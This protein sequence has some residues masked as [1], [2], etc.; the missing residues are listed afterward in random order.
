MGEAKVKRQKQAQQNEKHKHVDFG[1]V[2]GAVNRLC[3]AA[4]NNYGA[5][6]VLQAWLAQSI[7]KK[8]D[9]DSTI[10]AG[11]SAWRVGNGDGDVISHIPQDAKPVARATEAAYHAWLQVGSMIFDVTTK[12]LRA[13][14]SMIDY[15]DGGNTT[16][17]W[18]PDFL[19]I[20]VSAVSSYHMVKMGGAGLVHYVAHPIV[21]ENILRDFQPDQADAD[22]AWLLYSNPDAIVFGPQSA[23]SD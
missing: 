17:D 22:M 6:C 20:D 4:S 7:L 9:V 11:F 18:A 3:A 5:D 19:L 2:A 13:K 23:T 21:R 8:L 10:R 12:Q 16:V 14:A 1:R 15:M